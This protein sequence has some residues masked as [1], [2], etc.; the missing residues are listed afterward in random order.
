MHT[1]T[2]TLTPFSTDVR[3]DHKNRGLGII[4]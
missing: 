4:L 3:N 1:F 2:L